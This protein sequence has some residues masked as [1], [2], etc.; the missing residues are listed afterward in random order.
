MRRFESP[1]QRLVEAGRVR[2][3]TF[4]GPIADVNALDAEIRAAVPIPRP[5]RSWRLKRWEAIQ[6]GCDRLF[7]IIALFDART[8]ALAQAKVWDRHTGR[9][10]HFERK[11][12]PG[13]LDVPWQLVDS[14]L[15]W[16]SRDAHIAFRNRLG[17]GRIEVSFAWPGERDAPAVAGEVVLD[18][19]DATPQVVSI[20][21]GDNH[22]M[23]SHKG[24]TAARGSVSIGDDV[25]DLNGPDA[26][27]MLD[28]HKGYYAIAMRWDWVTGGGVDARGRRVGFNLTRNASRDP[29]AYNENCLW[30]DGRAHLLPPV[31]FERNGEGAGA[32]WQVR[33][34]EG[35]V[36]VR[37]DVQLDARLELNLLIIESRYRGPFGRFSG[38]IVDDDG[39]AVDLLGL[40][41]MGEDFYLRC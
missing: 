25:V 26:F 16:S 11:L 17:D 39:D 14:D 31:T 40:F 41:G 2:F 10:H 34:D 23:Y 20:P 12:R 1:P 24:M 32:W 30:V 8:M 33:D 37:F 22:G 6:I 38:T 27:A 21:F 19:R 4:D 15:A 7:M 3:G 18:T 29:A 9:L 36:D 35:R 5:L 13:A 28:D